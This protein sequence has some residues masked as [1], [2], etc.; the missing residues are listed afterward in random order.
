M[1][2]QQYQ[3][4]YAVTR[5]PFRP[6]CDAGLLAHFD[7]FVFPGTPEEDSHHQDQLD[8]PQHHPV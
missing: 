6:Y 1:L 8:E 4:A 3:L 7:A 5:Q 2:Q